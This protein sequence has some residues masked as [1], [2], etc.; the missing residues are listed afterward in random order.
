MVGEVDREKRRRRVHDNFA[1]PI[2]SSRQTSPQLMF[3]RYNQEMRKDQA[4]ESAIFFPKCGQ[5]IKI[6]LPSLLQIDHN[7]D[8]PPQS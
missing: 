5:K 2:H 4:S 3:C 6:E 8:A 7:E 1:V